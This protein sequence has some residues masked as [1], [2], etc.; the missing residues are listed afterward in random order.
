MT[1][2]FEPS[3]W[4]LFVILCVE[5]WPM[6]T[7]AMTEAMPMTIPKI[8]S[9]ERDLLAESEKYVSCARSMKCIIIIFF[10][11]P[12]N[13]LQIYKRCVCRFEFCLKVCGECRLVVVYEIIRPSLI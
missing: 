8:V 9:T 4:T 13:L 11:E 12:T 5:P 10:H 2:R 6:A 7:I 1:K 3:D